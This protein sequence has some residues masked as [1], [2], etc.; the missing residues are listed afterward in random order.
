MLPVKKVSIAVGCNKTTICD[1][2][3]TNYTQMHFCI[4]ALDMFFDFTVSSTESL[5]SISNGARLSAIQQPCL[6]DDTHL[7]RQ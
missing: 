5:Y 7:P 6:D 3:T 1:Y 4:N 2:E